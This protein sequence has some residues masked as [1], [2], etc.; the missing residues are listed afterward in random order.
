MVPPEIATTAA[1]AAVVAISGGT[2]EIPEFV[3]Q[4]G[5]SELAAGLAVSAYWLILSGGLLAYGFWKDLKAVRIT[6]LAVAGLAI[7][8]VLFVDLAELRALYRVGSLALLAA[9][10]LLGARAYY[11]RDSQPNRESADLDR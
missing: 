11:R 8:K 6:G 9:I 10:T 2:I 4:H 1:I 3:V 5:G 7:G